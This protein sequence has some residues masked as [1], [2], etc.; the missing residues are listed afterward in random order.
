MIGVYVLGGWAYINYNGQ[1]GWVDR[2]ALSIGSC[3]DYAIL[4]ED[5]SAITSAEYDFA[6][7][8]IPASFAN[9]DCQRSLPDDVSDNERY[10]NFRRC[11]RR[12]LYY[13]ATQFSTENSMKMSD[14]LSAVYSGELSI[15]TAASENVEMRINAFT[16]LTA[17][18]IG[19]EAL[20]NNFWAVAYNLRPGCLQSVQCEDFS[21]SPEEIADS[22]LYP[23]QS[24]YQNA[25]PFA[26][27]S[28]LIQAYYNRSRLYRGLAFD[29]LSSKDRLI[30]GR[31]WQWANYGFGNSAYG[32]VQDNINTAY[33]Y[34][35]R[36]FTGN[37]N[38]GITYVKDAEYWDD[39]KFAILTI[40]SIG[41]PSTFN[42]GN[43]ANRPGWV[44]VS[45]MYTA[46]GQPPQAIPY[47]QYIVLQGGHIYAPCTTSPD[48][49]YVYP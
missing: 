46:E 47:P 32:T 31:P 45:V 17:S 33:C 43:G 39:Y 18:Q 8:S 9:E 27:D 19:R 40:R 22:Y 10:D 1:L 6:I 30:E 35:W 41:T 12:V 16:S 3:I 20:I 4:N 42:I 14:V 26:A 24:W 5:T 44:D 34:T 25:L 38:D 36:A 11:A 2:N 15:L 13:F 7:S 37:P 21:L 49:A 23:V 48:A 29:A 28:S